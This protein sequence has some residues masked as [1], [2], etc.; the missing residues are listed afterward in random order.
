M[1][2][3]TRICLVLALGASVV[4]CGG[5]DGPKQP[6]PSVTAGATPT[7]EPSASPSTKGV[8]LTSTRPG[9]EGEAREVRL[10][11]LDE[12]VV[13]LQFSLA[14]TGSEPL[15]LLD[16]GLIDVDPRFHPDAL[17]L[18]DPPRATFHGLALT[19]DDAYLSSVL[20]DV[21]PGEEL[22]VT[23]LFPAPAA[24]ATSVLVQMPSFG[25]AEV[26]VEPVGAT[27]RPDPVLERAEDMAEP[28]P[29]ATTRS[30]VGATSTVEVAV[31][32]APVAVD[33]ALPGDIL[34]ASGSAALSPGALTLIE[35]A[36]RQVNQAGGALTVAGHTDDV[37]EEAANQALSEQ[38]ARAVADA[39]AGSLSSSIPVEVAGFGETRPVAEGT[40]ADARARNRRVTLRVVSSAA[41]AA[42]ELQPR[43]LG[44]DLADL[45]A[46]VTVEPLRRSGKGFSLLRFTVQTKDALPIRGGGD[47]FVDIQGGLSHVSLRD[48]A[49]HTRSYPPVVSEAVGNDFSV[50]TPDSDVELPAGSAR[51][52]TVAFPDPAPGSAT[53]TLEVP[54]LGTFPVA[55]RG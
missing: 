35:A 6:D 23:A 33:L 38:R 31:P 19:A 50:S 24:E 30:L 44:T 41:G 9:V 18:F 1:S 5:D 16:T 21:A 2:A 43:D 32:G 29:D 52:F 53:L 25:I 48:D 47:S 36:A 37:G 40:D 26:P 3:V 22:L 55:V 34:F 27:L 14:A 28:K 42:T 15:G 54:Q 49:A 20:D 12:R 8:T 45:G 7:S 17:H 11:R 10:A 4:G 46:T 51:T 39:L 13:A